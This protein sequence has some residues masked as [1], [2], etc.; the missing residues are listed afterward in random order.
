MFDMLS[1]FSI[2]HCVHTP[3]VYV[4]IPEHVGKVISITDILGEQNTVSFNTDYIFY[5]INLGP[6]EENETPLKF[7]IFFGEVPYRIKLIYFK[8]VLMRYR[9]DSTG[10]YVSSEV[11]SSEEPGEFRFVSLYTRDRWPEDSN[12]L[13]GCV[14]VG[15]QEAENTNCDSSDYI[16]KFRRALGIEKDEINTTKFVLRVIL[17]VQDEHKPSGYSLA[18]ITVET[19]PFSFSEKEKSTSLSLK[20]EDSFE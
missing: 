13:G 18:F 17:T 15:R 4:F 16:L 6:I 7:E 19:L 11:G 2:M 20:E 9:K 12:L 1:F 8:T 5:N 10:T 3:Y 14:C